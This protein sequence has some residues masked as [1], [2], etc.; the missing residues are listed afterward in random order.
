M[1]LKFRLLA[2]F[3]LVVLLLA[4]CSVPPGVEESQSAPDTPALVETQ[5]IASPTALPTQAPPPA[6]TPT[7][8]PPTTAP[9]DIQ[10]PTETTASPVPP[11][12]PTLARLSAGQEPVFTR[13]QMFDSRAGWATGGSKESNDHLFIT[14]DGGNTWSDVTPAQPGEPG[15]LEVAAFFL[16]PFTAWATFSSLDTLLQSWPVVWRTIDAGQ[17][18]QSSQLLDLTGLDQSYATDLFFADGQHGWLLTHVGVGMSHDYVTLFRTTD[19]GITW[20]RLLDPYND[21]QIQIC[22][23]TGL[24][25]LD[26]QVGWLTGD[27]GG[28]MSGAFLNR[29]TDGGITWT[30][31]DLPA[32]VDQPLLYDVNTWAACGS[33][34]PHFLDPQTAVLGVHCTLYAPDSSEPTFAYYLYTTQDGGATWSSQPYPGGTLLFVSPQ[35]GWAL[36]RDIYQTADGGATWNLVND[37]HWDARFNFITPQL[38]WAASYTETEHA[39][40]ATTDGGAHWVMLGPVIAP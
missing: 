39:L 36:A 1:H 19:G 26:S 5:D 20:E 6:D 7:S 13:L 40:V 24:L 14:R 28:V 29:T 22:Q 30:Y 37:V 27:C 10:A 38:G 4:A 21:G 9:V 11:P 25:F 8:P 18:W 15:T 12:G 35:D 2:A 17:T 23:K 16:D 33:Y 3:P 34:D 31:I 32:P